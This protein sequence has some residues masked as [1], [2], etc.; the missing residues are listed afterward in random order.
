M[1]QNSGGGLEGGRD[2][3]SIAF[4]PLENSIPTSITFFPYPTSY[5]YVSTSFDNC[6]FVKPLLSFAFIYLSL[7]FSFKVLR[8]RFSLLPGSEKGSERQ[9]P[10]HPADGFEQ[11]FSVAA[12]VRSATGERRQSLAFYCKII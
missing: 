12:G 6:P 9:W 11:S 8:R 1:E 2:G 10:P 4:P 3:R 5:T 7:S